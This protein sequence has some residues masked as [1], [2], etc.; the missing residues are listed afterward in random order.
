MANE[1]TNNN[2]LNDDQINNVAGG[3][4][5]VPAQRFSV[6]DSVLL[7]IYPEYGVGTV[8]EARVE[9]HGWV[10]VVQFSAGMMTADEYEFIP[11]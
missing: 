11:A 4:A 1:N 6:G 3:A 9:S 2:L 7:R 5:S 8:R 10:Y